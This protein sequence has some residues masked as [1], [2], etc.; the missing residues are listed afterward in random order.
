MDITFI[1]SYV[2]IILLLFILMVLSSASA[3]NINDFPEKSH[4]Y[5]TQA[6][7]LATFSMLGFIGVFAIYFFKTRGALGIFGK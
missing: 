3:S 6:A 1:I 4:A 5:S 2:I 7:L